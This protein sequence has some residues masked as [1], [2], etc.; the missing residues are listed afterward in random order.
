MYDSIFATFFR[1]FSVNIRS[2]S[3]GSNFR[4]EQKQTISANLKRYEHYLCFDAMKR[5]EK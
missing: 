5:P 1:Q 4:R 2:D 3:V